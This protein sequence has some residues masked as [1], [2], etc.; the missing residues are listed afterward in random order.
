MIDM[1]G[2]Y[3]DDLEES[4]H[5]TKAVID[6]I[7]SPRFLAQAGVSSGNVSGVEM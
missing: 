6:E 4:G 5:K 3:A 7:K 1:W 2:V